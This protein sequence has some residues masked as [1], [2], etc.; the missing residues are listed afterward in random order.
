MSSECVRIVH[1]R[2]CEEKHTRRH[3][4]VIGKV[5]WHY[6]GVFP[7]IPKKL[8]RKTIVDGSASAAAVGA[9]DVDMDAASEPGTDSDVDADAH[10]FTADGVLPAA[11][12]ALH[13][14]KTA[15]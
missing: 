5:D 11:L 4:S 1:P 13:T 6:P 3:C 9:G 15:S 2:D 8:K 12:T 7:V 10:D 14:V